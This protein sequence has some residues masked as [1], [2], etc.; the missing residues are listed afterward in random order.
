M[1]A[2]VDDTAKTLITLNVLGR[3][4]GPDHMIATFETQP[5]FRTYGLERDP[6]FSANCNALTALLN[7]P[8]ASQ[9]SPQI[10]KIVTFPS[11]H[12][13]KTHGHI[14]DKWNLC[15]LYPN[16]L[17]IEAF[18]DLFSPIDKGSLDSDLLDFDIHCKSAIALFPACLRTAL[19]QQLDGSWYGSKEPTAYAILT[20]LLPKPGRFAGPTWRPRPHCTVRNAGRQDVQ[21]RMCFVKSREGGEYGNMQM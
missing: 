5:H 7:T 20:I 8:H 16:M 10:K 13:W 19:E 15:H 12:W 6:S 17:F 1:E 9:A 21:Q 11:N 3:P 14:S 18:V 2:D 4:V